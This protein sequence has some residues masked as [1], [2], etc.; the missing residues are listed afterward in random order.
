MADST[1]VLCPEDLLSRKLQNMKVVCMW[2]Y[3]ICAADTDFFLTQSGT[4]QWCKQNTSFP[5]ITGNKYS[6][7]LCHKEVNDGLGIESAAG[8]KTFVQ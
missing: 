2:T 4:F 1:E 3:D 6:V 5:P 8:F 7:L